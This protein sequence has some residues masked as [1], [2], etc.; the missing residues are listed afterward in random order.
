MSLDGL[1][2]EEQL[3]GDLGIRL[4]V[5]DEPCHLEFA[6]GQR[7]DPGSVG[8]ARPRATVDA[9]PEL[10]QLAFRLVAV[11]QRAESQAFALCAAR[12]ASAGRSRASQQR[13]STSR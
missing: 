5:D 6:F 8:L 2:A 12:L 13:A 1:L 10:S 4:A 7:L 3:R 9:M 11:S